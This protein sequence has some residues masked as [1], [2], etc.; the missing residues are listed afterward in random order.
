MPSSSSSFSSSSSSSPS[1]SSSSALRLPSFFPLVP[2][3]CREASRP[4]FECFSA[5][6][7]F[8]GAAAHEGAGRAALASCA[9]GGRLDA[10]VACAEANLSP[11]QRATWQAPQN[12]LALAG[13]GAPAA[14]A[15]AADAPR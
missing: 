3:A 14:P 2:P 4:F 1:S 9:A 6:S 11:K 10:Y 13:A 7:A 12:Y 5:E 15:G 8:D